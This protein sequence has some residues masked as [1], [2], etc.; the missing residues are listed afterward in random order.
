MKIKSFIALL[1]ASLFML[2][3]LTIYADDDAADT[4][5]IELRDI[6]VDE[7]GDYMA[8]YEETIEIDGA[9][10]VFSS[11]QYNETTERDVINIESA[12]MLSSEE[13]PDG[14]PETVVEGVKYVLTG[15]KL[16][17]EQVTGRTVHLTDEIERNATEDGEAKEYV[18]QEVTDDVTGEE[19]IAV[20]P[21]TESVHDRTEWVADMKFLV[22]F[23]GYNEP[24]I[25]F[26]GEII[27]RNDSKP[28]SSDK[29]PLLLQYAKLSPS[30]VRI[31]DVSWSGIAS[32]DSRGVYRNATAYAETLHDVYI[33]H[34]ELEYGLP[35]LTY[36]TCMY[37]Y[38][39]ADES[40]FARKRADAVVF[41]RLES[42]SFKR[43]FADFISSP[44][45]IATIGIAAFVII[46]LIVMFIVLKNVKRKNNTKA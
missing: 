19:F 40:Y 21:L 38:T 27:P 4:Y 20:L 36:V 35:D 26:M 2:S 28:L 42:K 45:G 1:L 11:I 6:A 7:N 3:G 22:R 17:R 37:E 12:K 41:Y 25:L 32:T 13:I 5:R 31:T 34:Y 16:N 33:D 10:Y 14:K 43:G 23:D 18:E 29:Y 8:S 39:E 44:V 46:G 30:T 15:R 9:T 24:L